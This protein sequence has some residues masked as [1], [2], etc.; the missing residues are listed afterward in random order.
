MLYQ[1]ASTLVHVIEC[2]SNGVYVLTVYY[3]NIPCLHYDTV[4]AHTYI[5]F[6]HAE[7]QVIIARKSGKRNSDMILVRKSLVHLLVANRFIL[8]KQ[9]GAF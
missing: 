3:N 7:V 5:I 2:I 1:L 8:D 9:F 6:I 4:H